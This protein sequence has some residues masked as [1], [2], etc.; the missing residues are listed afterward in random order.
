MFT[1]LE[2]GCCGFP[3]ERAIDE[4][5]KQN[6]EVRTPKSQLTC[7]LR[8]FFLGLAALYSRH[9]VITRL[10]FRWAELLWL[11]FHLASKELDSQKPRT[12]LNAVRVMHNYLHVAE[13][14]LTSGG[15]TWVAEL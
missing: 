10:E 2:Y 12:G 6:L 3:E 11:C 4:Y 7:S 8:V 5:G 1:P 9:S 15:R 13:K 14:H